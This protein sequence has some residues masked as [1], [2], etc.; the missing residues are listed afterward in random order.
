MKK[1]DPFI[2]RELGL[3]SEPV[4]MDNKSHAYNYGFS[5]ASYMAHRLYEHMKLKPYSNHSSSGVLDLKDSIDYVESHFENIPKLTV[6]HNSIV[7]VRM[8]SFL[9]WTR[10]DSVNLILKNLISFAHAKKFSA[11]DTNIFIINALRYFVLL[12]HAYHVSRK[13]QGSSMHSSTS[14][15]VRCAGNITHIYPNYPNINHYLIEVDNYMFDDIREYFLKSQHPMAIQENITPSSQEK[16]EPSFSMEK[17][18]NTIILKI[19]MPG[20][21]KL[22]GNV[23]IQ[24]QE[25]FLS[26]T[27][28]VFV[29]QVLTPNDFI[30]LGTYQ[31]TISK[32]YL[33]SHWEAGKLGIYQFH[34]M[35]RNH[36]NGIKS[37]P[38]V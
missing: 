30:S 24:Y 28:S 25:S 15:Y 20:F 18:E 26:D 37:T 19:A 3:S 34:F 10:S 36:K 35:K 8:N 7:D 33:L 14:D 23:T 9:R 12:K 32:G 31:Y 17:D 29:L 27:D 4:I 16:S 21:D 1:N 11:N 2:K 13:L 22:K 6:E 5:V 38:V